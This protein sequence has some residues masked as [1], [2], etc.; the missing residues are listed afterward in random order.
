MSNPAQARSGSTSTTRPPAPSLFERYALAG[1]AA[2]AF[3]WVLARAAVQSITIDEADTYL[4]YAGRPAPSHWEAAA[5]NHVLNSL[6][7]RLS[8]LLFGVSGFTVR[9]PALLGAAIYI[10][11][12]LA[13]ANLLPAGRWLRWCLLVCLTCNPFVMD[14]LVAARGYSLALG[15]FL[16]AIALAARPLGAQPEALYHRSAL[17]SL[18]AGLSFAA[19][20]SFALAD[21]T[22]LLLSVLWLQLRS[23]PPA[24]SPRRKFEL[25]SRLCAASALPGTAAALLLTESALR[26]W[27]R[28][29]FIFGAT[30]L[31]QTIHSVIASSLFRPNP[32]L[33]SPDVYR[34]FAWGAPRL[35]P[36]LGITCALRLAAF[37]LPYPKSSSA[38]S[39]LAVHLAW[40][41]GASVFLLLGL[42]RLLY[43][44]KQIYMPLERTAVFFAPLVVLF[45]CALAAVPAPTRLANAAR[46]FLLAA[47]TAMSLYFLGCFRLT[48]FRDWE[49]DADVK[50]LYSVLAW[51][52]RTYGLNDI[53]SN[54]R[55]AASLNFYR[56]AGWEPIPEI[57]PK[58]WIDADYPPGRQIYVIFRPFGQT[59][60]DREHLTV[61]YADAESGAAVAIPP[62]LLTRHP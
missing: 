9:L 11:S 45:A 52:H 32:Y 22:V 30:S 17:C 51:Y 47:V 31:N 15:F 18:C 10:A 59:F 54:W 38:G 49:F 1:T 19:N 6:L 33:L 29:N 56:A 55:Y 25:Y 5:N 20:F 34:I 37:A 12:A 53:C 42:H 50:H 28:A 41:A 60:I 57:A 24:D 43:G 13:L 46:R 2:F 7:M 35:F 23:A 8:T 4:V 16:A 58:P 44:I 3:L 27:S 61:V 21:A 36:L 48:Y 14:Y 40:L 62:E 26:N 39:R